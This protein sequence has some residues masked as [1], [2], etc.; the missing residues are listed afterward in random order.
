MASRILL[1]AAFSLF[2]AVPMAQATPTG[3]TFNGTGH[4][5]GNENTITN[6]TTGEV[7]LNL[8]ATEGMSWDEV[9]GN[10]A[11]DDFQIATKTQ[12]NSLLF[13]YG[14]TSLTALGAWE[15]DT[16]TL[17]QELQ[18]VNSEFGYTYYMNAVTVVW[19]IFKHDNPNPNYGLTYLGHNPNPFGDLKHDQRV[20]YQ[21]DYTPLDTYKAADQ[22]IWLVSAPVPEPATIALLS[23]GFVGLTGARRRRRTQAVENR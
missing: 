11:F 14:F 13:D 22:G 15:D 8:L 10:A 4:L 19:G 17:H 16:D 5:L 9:Q 23:I 7:W 12:V 20:G 2:C 1:L 3:Y 18:A 6:D 21:D